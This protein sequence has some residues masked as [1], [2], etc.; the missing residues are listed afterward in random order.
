MPQPMPHSCCQPLRISK[1]IESRSSKR[2]NHHAQGSMHIGIEQTVSMSGVH[3]VQGILVI[4]RR[5]ANSYNPGCEQLH[6]GLI[7]PHSIEQVI[8]VTKV[9]GVCI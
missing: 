4:A 1:F 7:V 2:S 3:E 9:N 8:N 5:A 6:L